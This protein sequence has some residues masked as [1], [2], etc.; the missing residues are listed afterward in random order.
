MVRLP[1]AEECG[2]VRADQWV[3]IRRPHPGEPAAHYC[4]AVGGAS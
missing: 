4:V 3:C 2:L 1:A